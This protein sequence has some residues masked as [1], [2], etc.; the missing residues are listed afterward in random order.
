MRIVESSRDGLAVRIAC[1]KCGAESVRRM[2]QL[3]RYGRFVCTT[4]CD[5]VLVRGEDLEKYWAS[6]LNQRY[7]DRA[8]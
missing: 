1:G 7:G 5:M 4:C 3:K 6:A 2:A 8:A